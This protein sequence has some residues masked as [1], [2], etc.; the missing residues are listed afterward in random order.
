M[1]YAPVPDNPMEEAALADHPTI[2]PLFDPFLPVIQARSI[3]AAVRLGLFDAVGR[4]TRTA[5]EL[6]E[7]LS[8]DA[9]ALEL[10]M[11]VLLWRWLHL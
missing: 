1:R 11:R 7:A 8:V 9:D 5:E 3:M 4:S 10:M 2:R 6:A